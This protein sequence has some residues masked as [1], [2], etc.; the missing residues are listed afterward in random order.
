MKPTTIARR[1]VEAINA[2]DL[3]AIC[4]L[5][6]PD[7]RFIDS[8]G[9]SSSGRDAMRVGWSHYFRMVPDY[10]I[11]VER[12]FENSALVVLLGSAGGTYTPDGV[13]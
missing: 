1:F 10:T 11:E 4:G 7:H 13:L 2:H 8:L 6:A 9:T 12:E 5:M 3:D